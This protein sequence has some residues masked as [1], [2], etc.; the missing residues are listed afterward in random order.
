MHTLYVSYLIILFLSRE[1]VLNNI[2]ILVPTTEKTR[3]SVSI[4][5]FKPVMMFVKTIYLYSENQTKPI[6]ACWC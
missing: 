6:K 3:G 5:K 1:A 4:K 2:L